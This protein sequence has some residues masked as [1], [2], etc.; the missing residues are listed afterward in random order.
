ME[1]LAR[2]C[3]TPPSVERKMLELWRRATPEQKLARMFGMGHMI[4]ELAR[5]DV[6]RRYPTAAPREIDL[7]LASR[8]IDRDTMIK[9]FGWD[10]DGHGR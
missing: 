9:A 10:P 4:N 3:D 7:R 8:T 6:R 5:A 1:P 2:G